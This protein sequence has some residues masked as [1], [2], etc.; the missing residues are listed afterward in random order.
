MITELM[1]LMEEVFGTRFWLTFIWEDF[2][3]MSKDLLEYFDE[4]NHSS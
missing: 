2:L 3:M 1:S 4:S